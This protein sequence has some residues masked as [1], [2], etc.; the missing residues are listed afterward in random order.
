MFSVSVGMGAGAIV[1]IVLGILVAVLI[2]GIGAFFLVTR[3]RS[4]KGPATVTDLPPSGFENVLYNT[5][6]E[7][8]YPEPSQIEKESAEA[9]NA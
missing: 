4:D 1:G 8:K 2:V 9:S 5:S 3:T 6:G 7:I